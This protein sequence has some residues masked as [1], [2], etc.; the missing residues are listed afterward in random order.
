MARATK[1]DTIGKL[2]ITD[3][4]QWRAWL[5]KNHTRSD[6]VWLITW[7]K[8]TDKYVPYAHTVEEA[9]C[10][11]WIDS[12]SRRNDDQRR[13]QYFCPRKPKSIWSALNKQRIEKLIASRSMT[14][15]GMAKIEAAKADGSWNTLDSVDLLE[16]PIGLK[17]ALAK[18]RKAK[19]HFDAFPP[20]SR[21]MIHY[22]INS[23]RTEKTR[24]ARIEKTM[25][26]AEKNIRA[27]Q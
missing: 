18:N 11:G 12:I 21:K 9:L 3:R 22:W 8:H 7:K 23:A 13:M 16:M 25:E 10:F 2:E 5:R 15:A 24:N 19:K 27:N 14:K 17:K 4:R 6:G 20:S 1:L 26:L